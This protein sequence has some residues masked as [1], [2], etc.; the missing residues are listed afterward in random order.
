M[1]TFFYTLLILVII[2]ATCVAT[3]PKKEDHTEALM[4]VLTE[5]AE[6][7]MGDEMYK[8]E[9]STA[10][11]T[12]ALGIGKFFLKNSIKVENYF[13][14]SVGKVKDNVL[15]VGVMNHVFTISKEEIL[16]NMEDMEKE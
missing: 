12:F 3:C 10:V 13:L 16:E 15:S 11:S 8:N 4:E 2:S 14:F 1:K 6:E 7:K 9:I 5:V